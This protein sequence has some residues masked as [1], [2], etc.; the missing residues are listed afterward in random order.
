MSL[1]PTVLTTLAILIASLPAS[2]EPQGG[3]KP[4]R[5]LTNTRRTFTNFNVEVV[6]GMVIADTPEFHLYALNSY[7]GTIVHH[8]NGNGVPTDRWRTI[9]NPSSIAVD[10]DSL[11]VV[12]QGTHALARHDRITGEITDLLMLLSEPADIVIDSEN[13]WAWVSCMGDDAVLQVDI[14][15]RMRI[16][17]IWDED[18]GLRLKR[19]RFLYLDEGD[20]QD[21]GDNHVM[22]APL[23]SGNNTLIFNQTTFAAQLNG[24]VFS[25]FDTALFP[26][27]ALPDE[28]LF[29][30]NPFAAPGEAAVEPVLKHV[31][32]ILLA[33]GRNPVTG[34]YWML[35]VDE[36]NLE[37]EMLDEP[38]VRGKFANNVLAIKNAVVP[39]PGEP[40]A[41][42]DV[43]I[44]L[45]DT[46]PLTSGLQGGAPGLPATY[47]PATSVSFP[48]ALEFDEAS[49]FAA[50]ASST[51]PLITFTDATGQRILDLDLDDPTH[52][53][54]GSIA[55]QVLFS[56]NLM[57]VYCQQTGNVLIFLTLPF[58][59]DPIGS[60][61]LGEDPTPIG[62]QEGR[63][64]WYDAQP[65]A[66]GKTSCNVCHPQGGSDS[67]VWQISNKPVDEK[68]PMVT[69][70]IMGLE[71]TFPYHWRG[72]RELA[73][74]NGAFPGL[75][76]HGAAL[77]DDQL[78]RFM[79]FCFSLRPQPNPRQIGKR[80]LYPAGHARAG[81]LIRDFDRRIKDD[82]T[83]YEQGEGVPGYPVP[84]IGRPTIGETFYHEFDSDGAHGDS[85]GACVNCHSNPTGTN[86][87]F[88][89]DN[90][91]NVATKT[92]MDVA[93][94]DSQLTL[95]K[96]PIVLG[97]EVTNP[98]P[99]EPNFLIN[100]Q[101]LGSGSSHDG[102]IINVLGF[103]VNFFGA[104]E[105]EDRA[106]VAAFL[107]IF[108]TGTAPSVSYAGYLHSDSAPGTA[109]DIKRWLI[110]QAMGRDPWVGVVAFGTF[111]IGGVPTEVH[112]YF[113][114]R[115]RRF[116]PDTDLIGPQPF[117]AFSD[118][119]GNP[120][121][122]NVFMG[123]PPGNERRLGIDWD[124]DGLSTN[125][126]AAAGTDPWTA[127]S[128]GDGW[129]DGYEVANGALPDDLLDT[130]TDTI[131]PSL[132]GKVEVDF[133]NAS[134]A[135]LF[136][137][138]NEPATWEIELLNPD[139][140][141]RDIQ[142][143]LTADTNHTALVHKLEA[144]TIG[145]Q[146]QHMNT[147]TGRLWLTDLAGNRSQPFVFGP[148][149]T[150]SVIKHDLIA[151]T[152]LVVVGDLQLLN[153]ART[154][155]S[156]SAD[157]H[158]RIDHREGAPLATPADEQ[159][160]IAQ[161]LKRM[162]GSI[163]WEIIPKTDITHDAPA[164]GM[165]FVFAAPFL[166]G[167]QGPL[168][169]PFLIPAPTKVTGSAL[170]GV[171]AVH[172]EVANLQSGQEVMFNLITVLP[173]PEPIIDPPWTYDPTF[174]FFLGPFMTT[175]QFPATKM[176]NRRT[177]S[178]L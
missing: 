90:P 135:K 165:D 98:D 168:P 48:Y 4:Y 173:V 31:G 108:D 6:R 126:E 99:L 10:G 141:Q 178:S 120:G 81:T 2:A 93:Q 138:S 59:A 62:V 94:L 42:P 83:T 18:D 72:E 41:V 29:R 17:E 26:N 79:E 137:R 109:G 61:D 148:I 113:E 35:N 54:Q 117:A 149:T 121:L 155:T 20:P 8:D 96:Q 150:E 146:F 11:F 119:M 105:D 101:L 103:I 174:P 154:P 57:F 133:V 50:I 102:R 164:T 52:S 157:A 24:T 64:H 53:F 177:V 76:G 130:P 122:S 36:R 143:R 142:S 63:A 33:H 166:Y 115:S 145:G 125:A 88:F 131:A 30:I 21:A 86:G 87:D 107:D 75:L 1:C 175:W 67:L 34:A 27:G 16:L 151:D 110:D 44:D 160:V 159:V 51:A 56:S 162:P 128:D 127:D 144:S 176:K 47:S 74:F 156:Y 82:L 55:R 163:D 40:A 45:D 38:A 15:G 100:S 32:S 171:A 84:M 46:D 132:A 104:F 106:D 147:Y 167:D 134:Q 80:E 118:F 170:D 28:D 69:Q 116:V 23:V 129:P 136:F 123:V 77:D 5:S 25:G 13:G 49:G 71:D 89:Q 114:R 97:I 58:Q 95:K 68:G 91:S 92:H 158:V 169:G 22:V 70:P 43:F 73:D 124:G 153:E 12:G 66:D 9:H 161:L 39:G 14:S 65:S 172:F 139:N 7:E 140:P 60:L 3:D 85:L 19:P 37:A 112:W 78:D 152:D 111:P